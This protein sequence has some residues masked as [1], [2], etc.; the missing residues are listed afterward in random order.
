MVELMGK[1]P[2]MADRRRLRTSTLTSDPE[3]RLKTRLHNCRL[4][5]NRQIASAKKA[6]DE[7]LLRTLNPNGMD[8]LAR[9]IR[10]YEMQLWEL[11]QSKERENP[12][13]SVSVVQI[14]E[15]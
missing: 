1:I 13:Q 6:G 2:V 14:S 15:E 10:R 5:L 3:T 11:K 12:L 4:L 9:R 7:Q 8:Q